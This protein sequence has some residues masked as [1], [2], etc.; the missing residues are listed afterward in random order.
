MEKISVI[1]PLYNKKNYV[2][3][4]IESVL[5]QTYPHFELIIVDDG[6]TDRGIDEV[7]KFSDDRIII[8]EQPNSGVSV[9][10]NKGVGVATGNYVAFLDADDWWDISFLQKMVELTAKFPDAGLYAANFS[11]VKGGIPIHTE[12]KSENNTLEGYI[13]YLKVF[14]EKG[15]SPICSSAVLLQKE[16]FKKTQGF[17]VNLKH[18]E[19][20]VMWIKMSLTTKTVYT[21]RV[22][23]FYNFDVDQNQ[24][25]IGV[26]CPPKESFFVYNLDQFKEQ[27]KVNMELKKLLDLLRLK[28][29]KPYYLANIYTEETYAILSSVIFKPFKFRLFYGLPK[30][31]I[32]F[33][34]VFKNKI[35][36]LRG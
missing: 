6:S 20:L 3:K 33:L 26:V 32:R 15:D 14:Y 24:R 18:G 34:Y 21:H 29:L 12:K 10:R 2:C 11:I 1:I 25:A 23:S 30:P 9:A 13:N 28:F 36:G 35:R 4:T 16:I 19:D 27:E 22:L 17:D 7:K 31:L 8:L 5:A